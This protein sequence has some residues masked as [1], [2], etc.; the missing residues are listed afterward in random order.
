VLVA[1]AGVY[2]VRRRRVE[3]EVLSARGLGPVLLGART[4][5]E[6]LIPAAIGA[7]AGWGLATVLVRALGPPGGSFDRAALRS[8]VVQAAVSAGL[9]IVLFGVAAGSATRNEARER[10]GRLRD[11]AGRWP[12][13]A[14]A[15]A[16]SGA[17][18]YEILTRGAGSTQAAGQTPRFDLLILLFPFLFVA[19]AAG[20]VVRWLRGRLP[21]MKA[22]GSG[23]KR[24]IWVYLSTSR[25]ASAPRLATSLVTASALA[26]GILVYAG[27]LATSIEATANEKASLSIGSDVVAVVGSYPTVLGHPPFDWTPIQRY[28]GIDLFPG[29]GQADLIGVDPASFAG[30]ASWNHR[31][32]P[33]MG[34]LM[35]R[36]GPLRGTLPVI[37][38]GPVPPG[39]KLSVE[40]HEVPVRVVAQVNQFPGAQRGRLTFAADG[41]ALVRVPG[42]GSVETSY[43]LW[44]K[45]DPR[46]IL[47]VLRSDGFPLELTTTAVTVRTTPA[48]LALSWTFGLLEAFGVLAGLITILGIV[49]YLQARQQAREVSYAL[50]RRMGL[51][52]RVHRRSV[53]VEL[54]AMLLTAFVLGAVFSSVAAGLVHGRLDPIPALSPGPFLELPAVLFA[55]TAG[56]IILVCAFGARLVQRRADRTNVGEVMRLAG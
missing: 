30:T 42:I 45:G 32:G 48:F 22:I 52:R 20:L 8:S 40:G 13:E 1:V 23:P 28:P 53:L 3:I 39:L 14:A 51:G 37:S 18:L 11:A 16:L 24:S 4:A 27:V 44:A 15:L 10:P 47:P 5:V 31:L 6:S 21:R 34:S 12:W 55:A 49:L 46:R 17:S 56:G 19:G 7:A 38:T 35:A 2:G 33:S 43:E 41:E 26:I 54:L 29:S 36:L 9:G 25:L 50:A